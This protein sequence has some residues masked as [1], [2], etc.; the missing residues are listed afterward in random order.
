MDLL[1]LLPLVFVCRGVHCTGYVTAL[2]A[3]WACGTGGG[4]GGGGGTGGTRLRPLR[5]PGDC[6]CPGTPLPSGTPPGAH[7]SLCLHAVEGG[8]SSALPGRSRVPLTHRAA[9]NGSG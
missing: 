3:A 8:S 4:G 2:G 5:P 7:T 6:C 1:L 9:T